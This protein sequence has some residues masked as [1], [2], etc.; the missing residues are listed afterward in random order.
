MR[1][2][3][4]LLLIFL[5]ISLLPMA[6]MR[7]VAQRS[8]TELGLELGAR[9]REEL[10]RR[11]GSELARLVEDHARILSKERDLLEALLRTQAL[12]TAR[13]LDGPP[14]EDGD[15]FLVAEP[16]RG[17]RM[18]QNMTM[19]PR[20]C[21][22]EEQ[23]GECVPLKVD[24]DQA[25][26]RFLDNG[27][28]TP[29]ELGK[30]ARLASLASTQALAA[31]DLPQGIIWQ[32]TVLAEGVM[33]IYPAIGGLPGG[34]DPRESE[35]Y[36]R[37]LQSKGPVWTGPVADPITR[38]A[39]LVVSLTLPDAA[40]SDRR[41]DGV[42]AMVVP[43]AGMV[44]ENEHIRAIS[45][46]V[47][48]FVVRP[49]DAENA[50]PGLEVLASED[51]GPDPGMHA[52][53]LSRQPRFVNSPDSATLARV[54]EDMRA[55]RPGVRVLPFEGQE[56]LWAYGPIGGRGTSLLLVAPMADVTASATA[57]ER[58]VL[59]RVREQIR[60]T[61]WLLA[62][63]MLAILAISLLAS[64]QVTANLH[65]L[66]QAARRLGQGDF[67]ARVDIR[68]RD[69]L[70]EVGDTFN[71][72]VPALAERTAMKEALGLASEIQRNL[73]PAGPP[74]TPGLDVAGV[75]HYCEE[76]GGDYYDF[77]EPGDGQGLAVCVG[78]VS[79]HGVSAAL[80][81]ASARAFLRAQ[82]GRAASPARAVS[83]VNRLLFQD[84][85][86]TGHF[87]TL[88][89]MEFDR[90]GL[91]W[92]R[93]GHDPALAYDPAEDRF[94]E[95]LGPG[96]ALG[97]MPDQEYSQQRWPGLAPGQ[98]FCLATDGVWEA[99]DARGE[100]Y[101]KARLRACIRAHASRPATEIV[102]AVANDVAAFRGRRPGEDDV[103][104][105][106]VRVTG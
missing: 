61:G 98:I 39:T 91:T 78:D 87:M 31:Q 67:S 96:P 81:M 28:Q 55:M 40:G 17:G 26:V 106:I 68:T 63:A 70:R 35:W 24:F 27:E 59:D 46:N 65:K 34:W 71:E 66:A 38:Q 80:L 23:V 10:V 22:M 15:G 11:T 88:M 60:T 95:L 37:A 45:R 100:P 6:A 76:I 69:E 84:T 82:V 93:A 19:D 20:F 47:S 50:E 54:A 73:L 49:G 83:E 21:R 13:R 64:R 92:V 97:L 103:T 4:K 99:R 94:E 18:A 30:A 33:A 52:L 16:L 5:A 105:V 7:L 36:A 3:W 86:R 8:L 58:F 72:M 48:S 51:D 77:F 2:R 57:A 85:F 41:P 53:R 75:S 25:A 104:L 29:A 101:G 90:Q 32:M 44:H 62:T 1:I 79:G 42:A 102:E 12:E 9:S 74:E 14:P 43:A 56:S 89:L